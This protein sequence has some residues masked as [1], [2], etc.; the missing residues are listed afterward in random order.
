MAKGITR[1]VLV[2]AALELLDEVGQ[3]GLTTRALAERLDVKAP[4]LYWHVRNKQQLLDEMGSE[5]GRRINHQLGELPAATRWD[6]GLRSYARITREVL[7][8][9]R[10]AAR[11]FGGTYATDPDLVRS[12]E[13]GL[14]RWIEQGF[15]IEQAVRAVQLVHHFVVGWCIE[16]QGRR[17]DPDAA[18]RY[19]PAARARR[20]GD[21]HPL[22]VQAGE[23][24][25]GDDDA[26]FDLLIE[27][28]VAAVAGWPRRG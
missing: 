9:L 23:L 8:S 13:A 25:F 14:R 26:L 2:A 19:A 16:E 7:L 4:A 28:L 11:M 20:I 1:E 27:D 6:D 22:T 18:D 21:E 10:D 12:Q 3:D 5:L 15:G 24:L 17:Q